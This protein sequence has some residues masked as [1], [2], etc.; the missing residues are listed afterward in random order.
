MEVKEGLIRS[1]MRCLSASGLPR[2]MA[3]HYAGEGGIL[4]FHR[5]HRPQPGELLPPA[6]SVTPEKFRRIIQTLIGRGYVFLSMSAVVERLRQ[7]ES[8]AGQKFICLTFDDGFADNYSEAFSICRE[9]GVPMTVYLV[10]S[11]V[12]RE[13]P[14]WGFGLEAV[15]AGNDTIELAWEGSDLR[16][17]AGSPRQKRAAYAAIASRFV[18][19]RPAA[20]GKAC[21]ELGLR[22]AVDFMALSDRHALALPMIAEM[23]ASGLVEFGAHSVH[24]AHIG[25]LDDEAARREIA[26]CKRDCEAVLGEEVRHFAFP[27]GDDRAAGAREALFCRELGF[28]SAVTTESNTIFPSDRDRLFSLPRLTYNGLYQNAPLLDLLLSGTLP[29]LRRSSNVR[30]GSAPVT[31]SLPTA[32]SSAARP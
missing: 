31:A 30:A 7:G 17:R 19:A 23:R 2:L 28:E 21:E 20:I 11:F 22:Y 16:L 4:S 26:Q 27:Y 18:S 32:H 12:R 1:F 6:L 29:L 15:V 9:F 10:S 24:H 3:R 8:R 14:M 13:F 25:G 5:V